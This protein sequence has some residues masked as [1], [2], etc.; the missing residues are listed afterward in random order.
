MACTN[1][2]CWPK[3]TLSRTA[4]NDK[5]KSLK[6]WQRTIGNDVGVHFTL[7]FEHSCLREGKKDRNMWQGRIADTVVCK[8]T[9]QK[10]SAKSVGNVSLEKNHVADTSA[11]IRIKV[12]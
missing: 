12:L 11:V 3:R 10:V 2:F 5:K 8:N 7:C 9:P 1:L 4:E 6:H